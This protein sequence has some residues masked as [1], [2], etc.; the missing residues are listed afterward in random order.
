MRMKFL[1][2]LPE[3]CASTWCLF[4][5][6]TLNMALGSGSRTV[7]ITSVASSLLML[8]LAAVI[9]QLS[10]ISSLSKAESRW[11]IAASLRQNHRSFFCHRYAMFKMRAAAAVGGDRRPLVV[12][13][14]GPGLAEIY[15]RFNCENHAFTQ[16][17][18]MSA[19]SEVR[20]LRLFVKL[21]SNTVPDELAHHAE[22]I[23]FDKFLHRRANVSDCIADPHLLDAFV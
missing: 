16:P 20:H 19:G 21:G 8:S 15:H 22:A 6:S 14:A 10:A 18:A 4:S 17:G 3:T 7:A 23:G 1:R 5:S 2:I 13:H 12:Q 9:Y 11:L